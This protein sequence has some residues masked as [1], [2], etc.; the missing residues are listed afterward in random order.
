M[1]KTLRTY[2]VI[3]VLIFLGA[4]AIEFSKPKPINWSKTFN[5]THKIPY[6]T[7]IYFNELNQ[8]FPNSEIKEVGVTPFEFFNQ[9]YNNEDLNYFTG[10]TYMYIDEMMTIDEVSAQELLD[11]ASFG[12]DIFIASSYLPEVIKDSL[13]IK[14]ANEYNFTG[15][16]KFYFANPRFSRDSIT[17]DKGLT[18]VYFS[19]LDS[20]S[21]TVVG[22]QQFNF[23]E[24]INFVK[25]N[26]G[27]GHFYLHLQPIAFTNYHLLKKDN[28][29]YI[30]SVSSYLND[31]TIY[32][33]SRNKKRNAMS[34]SKLRFILNNP[35]LKWAWFIAL[36]SLLVF[37]VFNAKRKQRI[38]KVIEPHKNTTVAFTKTIGNLYYETKD[39]NNVIDKKITYFLEHLRRVY[40]ID[41]QLLDEKFMKQLTLKSGRKLGAIKKLINLI[42]HLRAKQ[43]CNEEDLLNLNVAIEDFH[44]K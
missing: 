32:F 1:T 30:A 12:N 40:F 17:I 11:F 35:P 44:K 36:I 16:A 27:E 5:E 9:S 33:D 23:E 13:K 20:V 22:Y 18:N 41:T 7:Y 37:V 25:V 31:E 24:K 4:I 19:E 38:V 21:S 39:H 8:L 2:L 26:Y 28:Q 10:G 43:L 14:T 3:L 15:K 34:N 42:A 29:K 6:G